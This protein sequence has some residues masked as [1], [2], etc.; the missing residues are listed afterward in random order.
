MFSYFSHNNLAKTQCMAQSE[1]VINALPLTKIPYESQ[2]WVFVA[3]WIG[4]E[5]NAAGLAV[6]KCF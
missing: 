6:V 1:P 3:E 2:H 5:V 4:G